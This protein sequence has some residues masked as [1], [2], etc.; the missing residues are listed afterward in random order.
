MNI[1]T[2]SPNYI[3]DRSH[4]TARVVDCAPVSYTHLDVYKRQG[5]GTLSLYVTYVF[6]CV[7]RF[8]MKTV[9]IPVSYTHLDVY[10]RQDVYCVV[11]KANCFLLFNFCFVNTDF[12]ALFTSYSNLS[13]IIRVLFF[14]T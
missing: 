7:C 6:C 5:L 3:L 11:F 9:R 4:R 2:F 12:I 8:A 10:K 13:V 1:R 14:Q